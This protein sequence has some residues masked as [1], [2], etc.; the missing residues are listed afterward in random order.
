MHGRIYLTMFGEARSATIPFTSRPLNALDGLQ[1]F[2]GLNTN[3]RSVNPVT[4]LQDSNTDFNTYYCRSFFGWPSRLVYARAG[5]LESGFT[6]LA[7][8]S[9]F[10]SGVDP[11][12]SESR[13][14]SVITSDRSSTPKP[15]AEVT[16]ITKKPVAHL[17]RDFDFPAV[18]L[19]DFLA[20]GAIMLQLN[21]RNIYRLR[22]PKA[23][24][25]APRRAE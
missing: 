12:S 2:S 22:S 25:P 9:P 4:G 19:S 11:E 6:R 5:D 20:D 21:Q 7:S 18:R 15:V 24:P 14:T 16:I 23:E 17:R 3:V 8:Y 1:C 13:Y 10:P